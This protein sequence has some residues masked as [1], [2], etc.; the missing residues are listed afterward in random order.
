MEPTLK[1]TLPQVILYFQVHQPRRLAK[2]PLLDIGEQKDIFDDDL[3]KSIIASVVKNCYLPANDL[4]RRLIDKYPKL[5]VCFSLSGVVMDQLS[6]YQPGV[7]AS[8]RDL[9]LSGS[10]EF[11]GETY[12]HSLS[13]VTPNNEFIRQ[14][15]SHRSLTERHLGYRPSVF[16]NTGLIYSTS[17]GSKVAQLGFKGILCDGADKILAGRDSYRI[18][19]HPTQSDFNI[20]FRNSELSDDISLRFEQD[21]GLDVNQ[22]LQKIYNVPGDSTILIGVDYETFGEH[23]SNASGIFTF[24]ENLIAGLHNDLE[25]KFSTPSEAVKENSWT[26]TFDTHDF[27]SWAGESKNI[28]AWLGNEIQRDAFKSLN[29]I[30][31]KVMTT[32]DADIIKTWR[33]LQT[34]DHFYYMSTDQSISE[35]IPPRFSHYGSPYEA[36]INY[37][38]VLSDF[39]LRLTGSETAKENNNMESQRRHEEVPV[40]AQQY[41]AH[42]ANTIG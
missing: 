5:K 25:V 15:E 29:A 2:K 31:E 9:A 35:N 8:F 14:V 7:L 28:S 33:N 20:L 36:F 18:Y 23:Y 4:L 19:K 38:N 22:Y 11:L 1:N 30:E 21:G 24:L 40:W 42:V 41:A 37:M 12:Y 32:Q 10:A 13:S 26:E 6:E 27:V 17:I 3:N 39:S 16:R 34:S